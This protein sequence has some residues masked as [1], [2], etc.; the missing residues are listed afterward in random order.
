M[1]S[2]TERHRGNSLGKELTHNFRSQLR[3]MN[4]YLVIDWTGQDCWFGRTTRN[5]CVHVGVRFS[6][7][8]APK[9][10]SLHAP[11]KHLG[12]HHRVLNS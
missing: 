11:A 7:E 5:R 10:M 4:E 3:S 2:S 6:L 12:V 1:I 9:S 8:V